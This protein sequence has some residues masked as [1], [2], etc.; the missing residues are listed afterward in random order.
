MKKI[1]SFAA[2]AVLSLGA[3]AATPGETVSAFHAAVAAGDT[4]KALALLSPTIVIYE[5]G[6]V[7][8]SREEYTSHHLGSDMEFSK[9]VA[10]K[11]LKHAERIDG[12]IATVLEETETTGAF[13]GKPVHSFGVE[14]A[15]LEKK[16][17]GWVIVH[18]HWSSRKAN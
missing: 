2:L 12:N 6:H 18:V 11:V 5:S 9:V 3:L 10:R 1:V 14:T 8:R 15:V 13:K 7:E 17:D 4:N 16:G